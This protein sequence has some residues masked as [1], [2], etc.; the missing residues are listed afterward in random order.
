MDYGKTLQLPKTDFP[1]RASLPEREPQILARW[2]D[3]DMNQKV[4]EKNRDRELFVL[5]DG[6][7]YAN[8]NIHLGTALNKTLKDI[9]NRF[10]SMDGYNAPYVPGWDT[11]GLPIEHAV[12]KATGANPTEL[13]AVNFRKKCREYALKYRDIQREE[14]RRLGVRGDW[15]NPYMTL[16]PEFEAKQVEVFG[17]MA[18]RGFIYK[19]LKPVYW[20]A[21]CETALAEA[22]VEYG[23]RRSPSIYVRFPFPAGQKLAETELP[24]SVIIWTTTPWTLPANL[25]I[26]LHPEFQYAFV[27]TDR[28]VLIVASELVDTVMKQVGI[29]TY[30]V[31]K[32]IAASELEHMH[33]R[34]PFID[35]DSLIVLADHVTLEQGTGC[36]HTAPGHGLEDYEVGQRYELPMIQPLDSRGRF[37]EEGGKFAGLHYDKANKEITKELEERGALLHISFFNH[38]YPNCWRCKEPVIY[39]ATEQWFASV[40]GFRSDALEAIE[41]V[42]WIPG[43]GKERIRN[44]VRDRLDWCIS[45]QRVWGVPIPIFYCRECGKEM[46]TDESIA[47]VAALFRREGSDSWFALEAE[48]ILPAGTHCSECSG[49][50]FRKETDIM[51]V[52]FD[53]GSS[54]AAVLETYPGLRWP[55]DLYL[56]GSDQHRGWFQSSLLTAVATRGKAPYRAVLT[57]GFVVDGDGRKMSKSLGNVIY[58]QEVIKEFGAD[59]LRLWVASSDFKADINV[60]KDILKQMAEVY[61]KIRNTARFIL[62]NLSDFDPATDRV[63]YADMPEIDRWALHRL[64][65]LIERVTRAYRSYDYHIIYHSVH[66][67]CAIDMSSFYLD[68]LKDRL[69]A[70]K[71]DDLQRRASQTVMYEIVHSLVRMLAPVLAFTAEEIWTYLP[72]DE[73]EPTSVQLTEWPMVQEAYIQEELGTVWEKILDAREAAA[74]ALELA[75]KEKII[76]QSLEAEVELYVSPEWQEVLQPYADQLPMIL[77]VSKATLKPEA[78]A[79][80]DA[81]VEEGVDGVRVMVHRAEGTKCERCWNYRDDVGQDEDHPTICGRCATVLKSI[82]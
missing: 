5:H 75:R 78:E 41:N 29:E 55:A 25:A 42:Q 52:W 24:V 82:L 23:E 18:K 81:V 66:N 32:K 12:I 51:D 74:K 15:E 30:K 16:H 3:D 63:A 43:W 45:R 8:G 7:P 35:R 38:Q 49:S 27:E 46:I 31:T 17:E 4:Q 11:H 13:G 65:R 50:D 19:G 40:E 62:G 64:H 1:M 57:H 70:E 34:H 33:A 56:E 20:C 14:F 36:V 44:M 61:R 22:E 72:K 28:E 21:S 68:V 79:P 6:P 9:V 71:A 73:D 37:M 48:E 59:I 39:R 58:P 80:A 10:K 54:H 67:F 47:A 76:G 53:S 2:N 69:Y 26:A 77:I 60:S